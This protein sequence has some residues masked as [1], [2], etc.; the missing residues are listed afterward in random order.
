MKLNKKDIIQ[1]LGWSSVIGCLGVNAY[2]FIMM[3]FGWYIC[4][5]PHVTKLE[6]NLVIFFFEFLVI[7]PIAII[8]TIY[9]MNKELI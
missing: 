2:D 1:I 6:P 8:Y 4:G 5:I 7:V 3:F 9:R